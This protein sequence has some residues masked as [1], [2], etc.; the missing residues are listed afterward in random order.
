MRVHFLLHETFEGP[1]CITHWASENGYQQTF[2]KFFNNYPLLPEMVDFDFLIIMGGGMSVYDR[3][4]I[5]W[6]QKEK[7][8]IRCAVE[9]DK[10]VLGICLGS[11]LLAATLG[12]NVYPNG[13]KEIGWHT[14]QLSE[15]AMNLSLLPNDRI[16]TVFHWH[17]DTFDL[18]HGSEAIAS[19]K[20][21][22]NQGFMFG[23]KV[24][25]LQFHFESTKESI[26]SLIRNMPGDFDGGPFVQSPMEIRQGYIEHIGPNNR[27]MYNLLNAM[28]QV[29]E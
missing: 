13:H 6:L 21:T 15:E 27:F 4:A 10:P 8:F 14:V 1:G 28:V 24:V 22:P 18:P 9:Y 7:E 19:S 11:Q 16:L 12:A 17:G 26:E 2:T 25:G 5:P 29:N 3:S 20:A 23:K